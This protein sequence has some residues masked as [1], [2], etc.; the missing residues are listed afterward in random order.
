MVQVIV[1]NKIQ[2]V[3]PVLCT[4]VCYVMVSHSS[5]KKFGWSVKIFGG[6]DPQPSPEWLRPGT[7]RK[8]IVFNFRVQSQKE[9]LVLVMIYFKVH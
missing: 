3:Y 9:T 5:S 6:L 2:M 4:A 7:H 1:Q 8:W